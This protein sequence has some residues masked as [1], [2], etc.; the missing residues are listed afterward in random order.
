MGAIIDINFQASLKNKTNSLVDHY[1]DACCQK[2][3]FQIFA[4]EYKSMI[5][6]SRKQSKNN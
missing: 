5:F 1:S 6:R 2:K 4:V 3:I